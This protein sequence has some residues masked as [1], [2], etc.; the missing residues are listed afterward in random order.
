MRL[1]QPHFVG[2]LEQ[3]ASSAAWACCPNVR[4][5]GGCGYKPLSPRLAARS[6]PT[7]SVRHSRHG[8]GS[9]FVLLR[10]RILKLNLMSMRMPCGKC[11]DYWMQD[12]FTEGFFL[13]NRWRVAHDV[14]SAV[15]RCI[16]SASAE[17]FAT[18]DTNTHTLTERCHD[19]AAADAHVGSVHCVFPLLSRR[20]RHS[21]MGSWQVAINGAVSSIVQVCVSWSGSWWRDR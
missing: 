6:P 11:A 19:P 8:K 13:F 21:A 4:P 14:Q 16:A 17:C 3:A 9:S 20:V 10:T 7:F 12:C 2:V 15:R 1:E 5:S 18:R